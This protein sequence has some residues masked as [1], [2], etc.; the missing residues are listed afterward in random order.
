AAT[1]PARVDRGTFLGVNW[2]LFGLATLLGIFR[3]LV[4]YRAFHRF[5]L[6][7]FFAL[8][9]WILALAHCIVWQCTVSGMYLNNAYTSGLL[10]PVPA[11][12]ARKSEV[13]FRSSAANE[14]LYL[15]SLWC[16]KLSFLCFFRRLYT[17]MDRLMRVW[18]VILAFTVAS[19][20][21]VVGTI[22]YWCLVSSF[23]YI[24]GHCV[25]D[26]S[27]GFPRT[28]LVIKCVL[29]NTTDVMIIA[30]PLHVLWKVR[31]SLRR[32]LAL[33][34]VFSLSLITIAF[35]IV[36]VIVV[37]TTYLSLDLSWLCTWDNI[38]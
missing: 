21:V 38:E 15:T 1:Q 28:T 13:F 4:R 30:I 31:I 26:S 17:N 11:D 12:F 24:M 33:G 27:V 9:A 29:D 2:G 10:D 20:V 22:P 37:Y 8:S 19:W 25:S 3:V 32:K 6:D 35:S 34:A 36:H 14:V 16:V 7:D 5:Q 23:D 18:W